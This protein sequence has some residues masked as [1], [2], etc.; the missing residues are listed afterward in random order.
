MQEI[1]RQAVF[2]NRSAPVAAWC[3]RCGSL[4]ITGQP[5]DIAVP[6]FLKT[7]TANLV[8]ADDTTPR[9]EPGPL[10]GPLWAKVAHLFGLGS[11]SAT[12]LCYA[13]GF[14]PEE[15]PVKE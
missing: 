10:C 13:L 2:A 11:S 15:R 1:G 12:S 3:P 4:K 6:T 9:D 14:K 5:P 8:H 7:I